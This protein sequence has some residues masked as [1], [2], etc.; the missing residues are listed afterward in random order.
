MW[1]SSWFFSKETTNNVVD[2]QNLKGCTMDSSLSFVTHGYAL[3]GSTPAFTGSYRWK[4][5]H[6]L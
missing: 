4:N 3:S 1:N 6:S 5:W 2:V